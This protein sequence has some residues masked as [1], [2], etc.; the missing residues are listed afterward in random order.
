MPRLSN[1]EAKPAGLDLAAAE[2]TLATAEAAEASAQESYDSTKALT[3]KGLAAK[4]T[5]TQAERA[6]ATAKAECE[7]A[8]LS[9]ANVKAQSTAA[10]LQ[11]QEAAVATADYNRQVAKIVLDSTVIRS[12]RAGTV[13][14]LD[15]EVGD[16]VTTGTAI[17]SIIDPS[18]M[19]LVAAVNENDAPSVKIGQPVSVTQSAF[20]NMEFR[21]R[22]KSMDLKATTSS[23]VSTFAATIEVPNPDGELLW[24]MNADA[25]IAV[26]SLTHVLTLPASAIKTTN[27]ES[28]VTIIDGGKAVAWD[29]QI[30]ATDGSKTQIIAGLDEGQE[31]VTTKKSAGTATSTSTQAAQQTG[32]PGGPPDGGLGGILGPMMR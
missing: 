31:V 21:G 30:G 12:P 3:D 8:R 4:S 7:S 9:Y 20:P 29:V 2:A 15:V 32:G 22:V 17:A 26:V 5:L 19:L 23:N 28:T 18:P 11:A 24:G 25:D 10:S 16:I 14:E 13:A 1:L 27:G 6:L